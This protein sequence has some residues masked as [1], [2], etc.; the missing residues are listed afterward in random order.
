[1]RSF[2]VATTLLFVFSPIAPS[3]ATSNQPSTPDIIQ[4]PSVVDAKQWSDAQSLVAKAS[5]DIVSL[6][7]NPK[8]IALIH[9]AKGIFL[10]PQFG[11]GNSIGGGSAVLMENNHGRWS[12]A[13]FFGLGGGS[14]GPHV[15]ANGGALILFIMNDPVMARF[16]SGSS[17]SLSSAPGTNIVNYSAATPQDMS[18][19]GADIVAW[20]AAGAPNANTEIHVTDISADKALNGAVY[21]TPDLRNILANR[22]PYINQGVINLRHQMPATVIIVSGSKSFSSSSRSVNSGAS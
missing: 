17:W 18:G 20:S 16:E 5:A 19:H 12:D 6:K 14:L 10:I 2:A 3:S 13:V 11:H 1:V 7:S 15:V 22:T 8:M 9:H 4:L 21:G